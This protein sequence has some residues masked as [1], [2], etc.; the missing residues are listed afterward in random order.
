MKIYLDPFINFTFFKDTLLLF[1]LCIPKIKTDH[2]LLGL[3]KI[4]FSK[5][6]EALKNKRCELLGAAQPDCHGTVFKL[7]KLNLRS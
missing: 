4:I 2:I 3:L 7:M 6:R 1:L 5:L